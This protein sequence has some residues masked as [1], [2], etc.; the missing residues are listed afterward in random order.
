MVASE[1]NIE[2]AIPDENMNDVRFMESL[3]GEK[4]RRVPVPESDVRAALE[5]IENRMEQVKE[6]FSKA[7]KQDNTPSK[8]DDK[9]SSQLLLNYLDQT[10]AALQ[11]RIKRITEPVSSEKYNSYMK[12]KTVDDHD[13]EESETLSIDE[14][15][16][17]TPEKDTEE[18]EETD[19]EELIDLVA[20]ERVRA[21]R[22]E[23]RQVSASIQ[24][25]KN[26]VI[27][28]TIDLSNG[29]LQ[30]LGDTKNIAGES[31]EL[32]TDGL[33]PKEWYERKVQTALDG[34][35]NESMTKIKE[36][37]STLKGLLEELSQMDDQ[38]PDKIEML[39]ET[40]ETI[41]IHLEKHE[42]ENQKSLPATERAIIS[43]DNEGRRFNDDELEPDISLTADEVFA[44]LM[45]RS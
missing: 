32:S 24:S 21:L 6:H 28:R 20:L 39:Q 34:D 11:E 7:N 40:L 36:M 13:D 19:E 23:V 27:Q 4:H 22:T 18:E 37:Q 25:K 17:D 8:P 16:N 44:N 33:S 10:Q 41:E 43:R 12:N 29:E 5:G 30:I 31:R 38:L 2:N 9:E 15:Q 1:S 42:E 45:S 26:S 35:G 3:V 14:I